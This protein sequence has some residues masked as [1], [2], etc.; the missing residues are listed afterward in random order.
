MIQRHP[1]NGTHSLSPSFPPPPLI[2]ARAGVGSSVDVLR[3]LAA[4]SNE[5]SYTVWESLAST[6]STFNKLFSYTDF[7]DSFKAYALEM[8]SP[9]FV[10]LGWE[11]RETDGEGGHGGAPEGK[12]VT[13]IEEILC[14]NLEVIV[15]QIRAF[16]QVP[17]M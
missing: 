5:T 2:Q 16:I 6:L 1:K 11:P 17:L 12:G 9:S 15:S 7:Y 14:T 8:F 3:L 13:K 4:F 10:R